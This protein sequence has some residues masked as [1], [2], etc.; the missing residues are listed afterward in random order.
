MPLATIFQLYRGGQ[1]Y[2]WRKPEYTEKTTDLPQVTDKLYHIMLYRVHIA[3]S[4]IRTDNF[5]VTKVKNQNNVSIWQSIPKTFWQT[6][7]QE[8]FEEFFQFNYANFVPFLFYP[9]PMFTILGIAVSGFWKKVCNRSLLF[10]VPKFMY[11]FQTTC[12]RGIKVI[13]LKP[14]QGHKMKWF[15]LLTY[16]VCFHTDY[17]SMSS[18]RWKIYI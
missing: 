18:S 17:V 8:I 10:I 4:G 5:S 11:L 6:S 14:T 2:W 16:G 3:M 15:V 9:N 7:L 1:F 12:F 13:E